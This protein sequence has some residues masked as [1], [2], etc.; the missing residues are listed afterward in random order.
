MTEKKTCY[1]LAVGRCTVR[2]RDYLALDT[3]R[4]GRCYK[5]DLTGIRCESRVKYVRTETKLYRVLSCNRAIG[6]H[7]LAHP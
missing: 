1:S 4:D 7:I 2:V 3:E 5:E 6:I